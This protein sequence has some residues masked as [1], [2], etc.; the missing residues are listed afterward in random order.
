M[1]APGFFCVKDVVFVDYVVGQNFLTYFAKS[2]E[3]MGSNSIFLCESMQTLKVK[4]QNI[5][6]SSNFPYTSSSSN[7]YVNCQTHICMHAVNSCKTDNWQ[8]NR[9]LLFFPL[10]RDADP[11]HIAILCIGG[12]NICA[13]V[14]Q[15]LQFYCNY[16]GDSINN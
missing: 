12:M 16:L 7:I 4:T 10:P 2:L 9:S 6:G 15:K 11:L 3:Y 14:T 8:S 13:T 1:E 5:F